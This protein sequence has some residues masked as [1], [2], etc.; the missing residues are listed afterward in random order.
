MTHNQR[1]QAKRANVRKLKRH[2]HAREDRENMPFPAALP[3]K[4]ISF[5]KRITNA[6]AAMGRLQG[7]AKDGMQKKLDR[8]RSEAK[9]AQERKMAKRYGDEDVEYPESYNS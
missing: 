4:K 8:L 1:I 3:P 7:P 2:W 6:V 5:L 9:D